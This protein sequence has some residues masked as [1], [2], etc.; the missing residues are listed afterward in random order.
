M[1]KEKH[2]LDH[3]SDKY[4]SQLVNDIKAT[5]HVLVLYIPLPIFWTLYD[6]QGSGWTFQARRM[7]GDVGFYTILPDQMQVVNP[8]LILAFIPIFTY[9]VYPLLNRC[10][11]LKTPL[12]KMCCGGFL[13]ATAFAVSAVVSMQL[14][15]TYPVLPSSGNIQ[16]RVYNPS[17]CSGTLEI[18][19]INIQLTVEP[20]GYY[21]RKDV[22]FDGNDTVDISFTSSCS[23]GKKTMQLKEA[24]AFGIYVADKDI[25]WFEDEVSKSEDGYPKVR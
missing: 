15:S 6:Q 3:A 17:N 14:E 24:T 22:K 7:D 1:K 18:S 5:L 10:H 8:L 21:E 11:L 25:Y 16:L 13:A 20:S 9:G 19:K 12:Q 23:Y 2:W 4:G